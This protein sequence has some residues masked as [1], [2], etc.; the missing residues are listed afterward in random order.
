MKN[1]R[2]M[3]SNTTV[4]TSLALALLTA[5]CSAADEKSDVHTKE[6]P[7]LAVAK[8]QPKATDIKPAE[9]STPI[10]RMKKMGREE[11]VLFART[12]LASRLNIGIDEV[13]LSGMTSVMWRSGAMGCPQEGKQYTDALVPGLLIML[14]VGNKAHRYHGIPA[15][16]PFFCPDNLAEAPYTNSSDI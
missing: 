5:S 13:Q 16:E 15:G 1:Y 4:L 12:D 14:R 2:I 10:D 8:D 3:K 6:K 9:S 11:Q 7:Q